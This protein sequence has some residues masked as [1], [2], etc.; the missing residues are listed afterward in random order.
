M[1]QEMASSSSR[2]YRYVTIMVLNSMA[3]LCKDL[4]GLYKS[5]Y[6][7][8]STLNEHA[9]RV[10]CW[11][12]WIFAESQRRYTPLTP[13]WT[14][15]AKSWLTAGVRLSLLWFLIGC[16]V[17]VKSG[18]ICDLSQSYRTIPLSSPKSLWEAR[19]SAI[20]ES[21]YEA[22]RTC[23]SHGLATL[24]DLIELQRSN[25]T[26]TNARRLDQ[27]NAGVDNLGSLLNLVGT[28]T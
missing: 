15:S 3:D 22:D 5:L 18:I 8:S 4:S 7:R 26:A 1:S 17:C 12:V 27:W 21:G 11:E 20:W 28:M 9:T 2:P 19:T 24:G 13:P 14:S 6:Q 25:Y 10:A 16:V 23:Q